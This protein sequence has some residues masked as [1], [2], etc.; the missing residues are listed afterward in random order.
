MRD[1]RR[2]GEA[3]PE[4]CIAP[5]V[6]RHNGSGLARDSKLR[7]FPSQNCKISMKSKWKRRLEQ[8]SHATLICFGVIWGCYCSRFRLRSRYRTK[9][10]LANPLS[11]P[12]CTKW[13]IAILAFA[14]S[15]ASVSECREIGP[16]Y[17]VGFLKTLMH[18]YTLYMY[19][20]E[21]MKCLGARSLLLSR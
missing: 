17:F 5:L 21:S 18:T 10:T 14:L 2:R 1:E 12:C 20:L 13:P 7:V 6:A 19:S 11:E 8:I 4:V 15:S 3:R 9:S 16:D